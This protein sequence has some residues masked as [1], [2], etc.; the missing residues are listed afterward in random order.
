MMQPTGR[1]GSCVQ[2]A[3]MKLA[4][5]GIL[6][7]IL[8]IA[9]SVLGM[10]AV[11]RWVPVARLRRHNDVAGFIYAVVGVVYGVPLAFVLVVAWQRFDE[12]RAT[13]AREANDLAD[14]Y[15]VVGV[16]EE[17]SRDEVRAHI[18]G[19]AIAT[20]EHEWTT[21]GFGQSS[22]VAE[23]EFSGIWR[24][25]QEVEPV[26]I[27]QELWY[28]EALQRLDDLTDNRQLRLLDSRNR[29]PAAMWSML[30]I[31]AVLTIGFSFLFGAR[32]VQAQTVMVAVLSG[33][34]AIVL[35][36]IAALERPFTGVIQ[37][38]SQAFEQLLEFLEAIP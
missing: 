24:A 38:E 6:F 5:E 10:W 34:I 2:M 23:A 20:I 29:L 22:E 25:L 12:S 4:L 9:L 8:V 35:Y 31:G 15:R 27:V 13:V 16:L 11:R 32:D 3:R 28:A 30:I 18:R 36:L 19:Y 26:G 1:P 21:L 17:P 7:V 33:L 37:L 14:L